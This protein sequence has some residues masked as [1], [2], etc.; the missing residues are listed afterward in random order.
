MLSTLMITSFKGD[1]FMGRRK[2]THERFWEEYNKLEDKNLYTVIEL[3]EKLSAKVKVTFR[4]NEGHSFNMTISDF[5]NK[6]YRCFTCA[7]GFRWNSDRF[8]REIDALKDKD[9]YIFSN[10]ENIKRTSSK[11]SV[12]HKICNHTWFPSVG[13]FFYRNTR[14][15]KCSGHARWNND[16]VLQGFNL[17]KDCKRFTLLLDEKISS[18]ESKFN[19][20]C[21][22]GHIFSSS[23]RAYFNSGSRCPQCRS[24]HGELAIVEFLDSKGI[25]YE[26]EKK[27]TNCKGKRL[28]PFDFYIDSRRTIIEYHGLQHFKKGNFSSNDALNIETLERTQRNDII[29]KNWAIAHGYTFIEIHYTDL[30][31]IEDI[32]SK[33]LDI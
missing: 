7:L 6:K 20:Q 22:K 24:S 2:W 4:C 11:F 32:L 23:P 33:E 28:L 13:G 16:R 29:K 30:K 15:P 27:F 1:F 18:E 12:T 9:D 3:P 10:Y 5:F 26:R 8:L 25:S 14:C 17:S 21:E 19:V 31:R